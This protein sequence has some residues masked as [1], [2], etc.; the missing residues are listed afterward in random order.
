MHGSLIAEVVGRLALE[1]QR[2]AGA[3]PDVPFSTYVQC[4]HTQVKIVVA[5]QREQVGV[6][7][8][9]SAMAI[10]KALSHRE[11]I[12]LDGYLEALAMAARLRYPVALKPPGGNQGTGV[13][14]A[15]NDEDAVIAAFDFARQYGRRIIVERHIAGRDVL[16]FA[17]GSAATAQRDMAR[18]AD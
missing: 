1:L 7:A 9:D 11:S 18:H 8:L 17:C 16:V 6:L 2:V 13:T 14:T 3:A 15:S 10:V 5:Y 12:A 4:K